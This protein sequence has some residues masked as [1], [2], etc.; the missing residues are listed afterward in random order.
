MK[1]KLLIILFI[2]PFFLSAQVKTGADKIIGVYLTEIKYGKV[3]IYRKGNKYFGK[4]VW[5]KKPLDKNGKP[6]KDTNNPIQTLKKNPLLNLVTLSDLT[7][8]NGE[9]S[10][11]KIYDPK[12][13]KTYDCTLWFENGKLKLRGYVGWFYDT[14]TWTRV[15]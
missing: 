8:H 2:F 15:K 14:K 11:G 3:E 12:N 6:L 10:G 13:G 5:I 4:I 9:W 7:Y 1:T